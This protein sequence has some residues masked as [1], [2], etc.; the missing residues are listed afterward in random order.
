MYLTLISYE[1]YRKLH[2]DLIKSLTTKH[3]FH[4]LK[5]VLRRFFIQRLEGSRLSI[6]FVMPF[7]Q[8]FWPQNLW[9]S[10]K[11]SATLRPTLLILQLKVPV[12]SIFLNFKKLVQQ[13]CHYFENL[14]LLILK[15]TNSSKPVL[16]FL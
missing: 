10:P 3:F 4:L 1:L 7:N 16:S 8:T 6:I 9:Y 11:H 14:P 15:S 2:I 12:F 5:F 13:R